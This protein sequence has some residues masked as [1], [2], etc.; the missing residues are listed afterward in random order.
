MSQ[1]RPDIKARKEARELIDSNA[2]DWAPDAFKA[3]ASMLPVVGGLVGYAI[4]QLPAR[5]LARV[6]RYLHLLSDQ[7]NGMQAEIDELR[8]H[9][10]HRPEAAGLFEAGMTAAIHTPTDSRLKRL[11]R[12]V[13]SGLTAGEV[14]AMSA[15]RR[16]RLIQEIDDGEFTL[17]C[18]VERERR[19]NLRYAA[20]HGWVEDGTLTFLST[21]G[22]KEPPALP[23]E[24]TDWH[25]AD[26][27]TALNHLAGLGLIEAN[28][29]QHS[30]EHG[31]HRSYV[32]TPAGAALLQIVVDTV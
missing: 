12:V 10:D 17:L 28:L 20:D 26:L 11:A 5:Q 25:L 30:K 21:E 9:W 19:I 8:L 32:A 16:I 22:A 4:D 18:V 6:V 13:A 3:A 7:C 24:L 1:D 31:A 15:A 23:K 27:S 29:A 14:E 2:A